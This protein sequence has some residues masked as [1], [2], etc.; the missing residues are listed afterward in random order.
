M[1][2]DEL[3]QRALAGDRR[4]IARVISLVEDGGADLG[5]AMQALYP[6]TGSAYSVGITGAPGA[7]KSTLTERLVGKARAAQLTVGVLAIDPSS[8]FS[9]GALLGDRV[10]MQS[11]ATDPGVFIRSMAT[12][13]HLG[14]ISL[15]TPEAVRVLDA[16]G[17]D[18]VV[19]ET[20]GVGQAEVEITDACD[21]TLVV[22]NPGWGDAVQA[23]KAGLLE[24]ADVFV[25]NKADRSGARQAVQELRQM[26]ELSDAPWKP[27]IVET[28][29]TKG[30]GID[31]LWAAIEKHRAYQE[32]HGLLEARR[33]RRVQRE[34]KEIVAER[35]RSR[36]EHEQV[37]LLEEITDEVASRR[38]DPY[39]AADR[40]IEALS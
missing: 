31:E 38:L 29:A 6:R 32:E 13:G 11:H 35:Y 21:T 2:L 14:G 17:K 5:R 15:A 37:S 10:R 9:G 1:D 8:P 25:V 36:V 3:I 34:I 23:A 27:D 28:V 24:I 19:I 33:R 12:R 16:V 22:V 18:L 40:L 30:T 4:S 26:L 39:A 7:G 20:V